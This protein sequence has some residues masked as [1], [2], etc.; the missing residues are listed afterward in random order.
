MAHGRLPAAVVPVS[1]LH[2]SFQRSKQFDVLNTLEVFQPPT[3]AS[4]ETLVQ[5]CLAAASVGLP[6]WSSHESAWS[7]QK[8]KR[9]AQDCCVVCVPGGV[10]SLWVCR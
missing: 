6:C 3:A 9:A 1:H 10:M 7:G 2:H 5:A 8:Q 4:A